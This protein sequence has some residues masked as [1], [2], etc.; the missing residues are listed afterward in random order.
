MEMIIAKKDYK[1]GATETVTIPSYQKEKYKKQGYYF[2]FEFDNKKQQ[3]DEWM[4]R[5]GD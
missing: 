3:H 4:Q 5:F 2:P 1:F